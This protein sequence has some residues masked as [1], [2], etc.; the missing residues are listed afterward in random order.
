MAREIPAKEWKELEEYSLACK[1]DEKGAKS[2]LDARLKKAEEDWNI[3]PK[4]YKDALRRKQLALKDPIRARVRY[5][6]AKRYDELFGLTDLLAP[7]LGDGD[8]LE[9]TSGMTATTTKRKRGR[10]PGSKNKNR[11]PPAHEQN[12]PEN[13]TRLQ[14]DE[15]QPAA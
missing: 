7:M 12:Y 9:N 5:D 10:P 14:Q 13:V 4:D 6:N 2:D 8:G 15:Q 1:E 3:D 11:L